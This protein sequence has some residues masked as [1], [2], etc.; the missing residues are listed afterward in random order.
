[1]TNQPQSITW[2]NWAGNQFFSPNAHIDV[3]SEAEVQQ[4][5]AE[6]ASQGHKVRTYGARHSF[7]PIVETKDVLLNMEKITGVINIDSQKRQTTALPNTSIAD[8]GEPLWVEGLALANQGD[9]DTQTIAGAIATATHGSGRTLP[10]FSAA[11]ARARIVDGLGNLVEITRETMPDELAALQT[12]LGLLGIMTE[13]TIDVIPAYEL[14]LRH[15]LLA[16]SEMMARFESYLDD[17]RSFTFYWCPTDQSA[18]LFGLSGAK[19]DECY[20]RLL[21]IPAPDL[22]RNSLSPNERVGPSYQIYPVVYEPNFH[23]M[24]YFVPLDQ[25]HDI[26]PEIRK[27]MLHWFPKSIYPLEVR[28][29]AAEDAWL[30]PHYQRDNLVVSVSGEPGTD[31]WDYLRACDS[32]FAEF[33]GRPHWGKLHFMTADRVERLFPRYNDFVTM[34]RRFDPKGTYL[35]HHTQALF[36]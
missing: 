36:A 9:I 15:E 12:S 8:F 3:C 2:T 21:Q 20:L 6:A 27:L 7:T 11:L 17:Y 1:M 29:V 19:A 31:Y 4:L 32:L 28:N 35:N 18:G 13:V 30:S 34:R 24:E 10:S 23:E 22:D 25:A 33:K 26:L 5:V 14:H 16:F